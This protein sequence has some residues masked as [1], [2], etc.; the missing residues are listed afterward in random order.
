VM[1]L[2]RQT[3]ARLHSALSAFNGSRRVVGGVVGQDQ[4]QH[5]DGEWSGGGDHYRCAG[6][7]TGDPARRRG[8]CKHRRCHGSLQAGVH[9]ASGSANPAEKGTA[10]GSAG[11]SPNDARKS[12]GTSGHPSAAVLTG[13][14]FQADA[15]RN[16]IR[17]DPVRADALLGE[18]RGTMIGAKLGLASKTINN[19][20]SA[21][22]AKLQVADRTEAVFRAREAGLGGSRAALPSEPKRWL[23]N[24]SRSQDRQY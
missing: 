4:A 5:G 10:P 13:V 23:S 3:L 21:V 8:S 9:I 7:R 12:T 17:A 24:A 16:L 18:L 20:A 22:F 11:R 15:A 1:T 6:S 2:S 19:H 14:A